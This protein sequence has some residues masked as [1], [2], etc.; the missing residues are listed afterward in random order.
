MNFSHSSTAD[1]CIWSLQD[2]W[3]RGSGGC[4]GEASQPTINLGNPNGGKY[5]CNALPARHEVYIL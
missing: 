4:R 1:V 3:Y 5:V 2:G